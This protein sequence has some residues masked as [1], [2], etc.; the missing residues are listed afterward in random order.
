MAYVYG[1][2]DGLNIS[3]IDL[4]QGLKTLED[5]GQKLVQTVT[6]GG[7]SKSP[8]APP[9]PK[10]LIAGV[11]DVA[12]YAAGAGAAFLAWKQLKKKK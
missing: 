4:S 11:P 3:D 6:G 10:T 8:S 1:L 5:A 2:G 7:G 9:P 12:V